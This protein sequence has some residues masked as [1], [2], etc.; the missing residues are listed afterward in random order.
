M[1]YCSQESRFVAQHRTSTSD[2]GSLKQKRHWD[3]CHR[4]IISYAA[5]LSRQYYL[6][7]H[8]RRYWFY[9]KIHF[10]NFHQIFTF[11]DP[12]SQKT[13][14]T[15][16]SVCPVSVDTI[17]LNRIIGLDWNLVHPNGKHEFVNQPYPTEIVK[18]RAFFVLFEK[19]QYW[20][21]IVLINLYQL[22]QWHFWIEPKLG[23]LQYVKTW[24]KSI[25]KFHVPLKR[26]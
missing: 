8:S 20:F 11:W 25:S 18:I 7:L 15:K 21:L 12:L 16:V 9:A 19:L 3:T 1:Y 22:S 26:T 23:N 17:T 2:H 6:F 14:S 13:V 4:I 24:K 10:R 5:F